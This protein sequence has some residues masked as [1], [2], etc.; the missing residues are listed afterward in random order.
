MG[1]AASIPELAELHGGACGCHMKTDYPDW[2]NMKW[3]S[4]SKQFKRFRQ[5]YKR[6]AIRTLEQFARHI[7]DNKEQFQPTTLARARFYLNVILKK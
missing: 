4:F 5:E 3:G 1:W 6:S 7:I 2:D